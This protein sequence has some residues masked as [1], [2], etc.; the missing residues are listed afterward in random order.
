MA[1]K[2]RLMPVTQPDNTRTIIIGEP[3]GNERLEDTTRDERCVPNWRRATTYLPWWVD[4]E[5]VIRLLLANPN[6]RYNHEHGDFHDRQ[7][8]QT[9]KAFCKQIEAILCYFE[10][11]GKPNRNLLEILEAHLRDDY[12]LEHVP[13]E[14]IAWLDYEVREWIADSARDADPWCS[15]IKLDPRHIIERHIAML[16]NKYAYGNPRCD[17]QEHRECCAGEVKLYRHGGDCNSIFC[18]AC[19]Q[20]QLYCDDVITKKT[21]RVWVGGHLVYQEWLDATLSEEVTADA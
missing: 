19:Y 21:P 9:S 10:Q 4:E 2:F 8:G 1:Y 12:R 16:D 3:Y 5:M 14:A 6:V 7:S 15:E 20:R 11:P 17:C 13:V 18:R